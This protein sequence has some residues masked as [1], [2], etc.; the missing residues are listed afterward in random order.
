MPALFVT[1]KSRTVLKRQFY[2]LSFTPGIFFFLPYSL[3]HLL[4]GILCVCFGGGSSLDSGKENVDERIE[5]ISFFFKETQTYFWQ[6]QMKIHIS[7]AMALQAQILSGQERRMGY[8]KKTCKSKIVL[9]CLI[10]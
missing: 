1:A 6:L 7:V 3:S 2:I 5:Y 10:G 8:W 4:S 9:Q